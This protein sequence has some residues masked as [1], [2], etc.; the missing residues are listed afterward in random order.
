VRRDPD[1]G[2]AVKRGAS[3]L[4]ICSS[5][6][7]ALSAQSSG[8]LEGTVTGPPRA[9]RGVVVEVTRVH[10]EPIVTRAA[11]V[12]ERGRYRLDSLPAG[13]YAL[14]V[15]SPLLDSLQLSTPDRSVTIAAGRTTADVALPAGPALRD[16]VCPGLELG[17][18]QGVVTGH[19]LDAD[20]EQP[21]V[22]ATV[23]VSWNELI[24]DRATLKSSSEERIATAPTGDRGEY[25]LCD[26][27]TGTSLSLQ[28]QQGDRASADVKLAVSDEEGVRSRRRS[29]PYAVR[30]A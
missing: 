11:P 26:V 3:A 20:T 14:H 16:A 23:V 30:A 25:R 4:L 5:L 8:R 28:L 7:S 21:L 19:G 10:P 12:D 15:A 9:V 2:E 18:G 1:L 17:K 22:G 13:E 27:P 24:V 29:M 6:A